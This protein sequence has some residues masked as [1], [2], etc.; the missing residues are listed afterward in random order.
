MITYHKYVLL[1][2]KNPIVRFILFIHVY[3]K[4]LVDLQEIHVK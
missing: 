1:I 4:H 2:G 3:G